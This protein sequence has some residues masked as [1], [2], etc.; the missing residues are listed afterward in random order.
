MKKLMLLTLIALFFS[1]GMAYAQCPFDSLEVVTVTGTAIVD[2]DGTTYPH[3][4]LDQDDDGAADYFLNFGPHWYN[5][6][7]SD[8][9][10]P[11]NGDTITIT[12]G[13]HD[14]PDLPVI[15][16]YEINGEFWRD[17]WNPNGGHDGN[18]GGP[19]WD[20]EE[21]TVSGTAMIDTLYYH[22]VYF[23]DVDGDE[24]P[25]YH[26]NFGPYWYDPGT[27][28]TRPEDGEFVEITGG[29]VEH[30]QDYD[31]VIVWEINGEF[32]RD[33]SEHGGGHHD[34]GGHHGNHGGHGGGHHGGGNH[35]W[36]DLTEI[37]LQGTAMLDSVYYYPH[38]YIDV[39]ADGAPDY[40]LNF[41]PHW[42]EPD[43]GATRPQ[44]GD[45]ID[46]VG[47]LIDHDDD[48]I[49]VVVVWEI[50]GLQWLDPNEP[51]WGG[52]HFFPGQNTTVECPTD[53]QS[54]S[55]F[56]S[57]CMN[58]MMFPDHAYIQYTEMQPWE[59]PQPGE[60]HFK[61][62]NFTFLNMEQG[63]SDMMG[64]HG[65]IHFMANIQVRMHY[66]DAELQ[67]YGMTDSDLD[68]YR[69]N[70]TQDTWQAVTGYNVD[71]A[72]NTITF[73]DD[74][75]YAYYAIA[76]T[77]DVLGTEPGQ[78]D[79]L[80]TFSALY[81]NYPN[82]FNP[83]TQI[84]YE[85]NSSSRVGLAIYDMTGRLVRTLVNAEQSG[86]VYDVVWNGRNDSNETVAS[87]TYFYVLKVDGESR[88]TRTM[89]LLK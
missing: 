13:T 27:G 36:A 10:R 78:T 2:S 51:G 53:P 84:R 32:W 29:L 85:L 7:D 68:V 26:L 4:Y 54:W 12:G 40:R 86:G 60:Q 75:I 77:F 44:D 21:V 87:G 28:A 57:N 25:D 61:G 16:V 23:L 62:F 35:D 39:D 48:V 66:T 80:P 52:H 15:I 69:W 56:P 42:Y 20:W 58:G 79:N 73:S 19:G 22:P 59:L 18:G 6:E 76:G 55:Q 74:N 31:T 72:N 34:G 67:Q 46:I 5:P 17:P 41:G 38:Y 82:P 33:P 71:T 1:V 49:D 3:Y 81:Q 11:E 50:N 14:L 88:A 9:T 43:T 63:G 89:T 8:A 37:T 24:T 47:G 65:F 70:E 64:D 30:D 45:T 83:M